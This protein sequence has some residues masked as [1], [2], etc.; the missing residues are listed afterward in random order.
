MQLLIENFGA[1]KTGT[2]D[3]TKQLYVFVGYNNSGKTY[4]AQLMWDIFTNKNSLL[5]TTIDKV[6]ADRN[7]TLVD[8]FE[9][10]EDFITAVLTEFGQT[11]KAKITE[12]LYL[13]ANSPIINNAKFTILNTDKVSK[14][15]LEKI[16][17]TPYRELVW[18]PLE[19]RNNILIE[20]SKPTATATITA[21]QITYVL[22]SES[23]WQTVESF[24]R[25]FNHTR[26]AYVVGTPA[27]FLLKESIQDILSFSFLHSTTPIFLPSDRLFYTSKY[28]YIYG[29][30]R[31]NSDL[32]SKILRETEDVGEA[33][34][35]ARNLSRP[36]YTQ[37]VNEVIQLLFKLNR[38]TA[39]D[40]YNQTIESL[41]EI[42]NGRITTKRT[43]SISLAEFVLTMKNGDELPMYLA[44]SSVNQL[45]ALYL[46]LKY[47]AKE[48]A[49]FLIIDEPEENLH[50]QNQIKLTD[51]LLKFGQINNNRLL[52]T[53]HSPLIAE[54]INNYL[55]LGTILAQMGEEKARETANNTGIEYLPLKHEDVGI[56]FFTGNQITAYAIDDYGTIFR[57]FKAA[58]DKVKDTTQKL[59][60]TLFYHQNPEL[61]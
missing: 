47:W 15:I 39:N 43:E 22:P 56:Y 38:Q 26:I 53:T 8:S 4:I 31:E 32:L 3:L 29:I 11:L 24:N 45:S 23:E 6:I 18:V 33:L 55:T 12:T 27:E 59:G 60:E 10:S 42:I 57:D 7:I 25:P 19:P 16:S 51:L 40:F 37:A 46:Y 61:A 41:E 35:R 5:A 54:H 13:D 1:I 20:L 9:I 49:N 30:E 50:P 58:T 48:K 34:K 21:T 17:N 36:N 44:S 2:I 14:A 52:M 28:D